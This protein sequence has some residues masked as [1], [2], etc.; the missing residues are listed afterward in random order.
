MDQVGGIAGTVTETLLLELLD[1]DGSSCG[2]LTD[3]CYD[4]ADPYAVTATFHNGPQPVRWTFARSLLLEGMYA[5]VGEGDVHVWPCLDADGA[6]VVMLE[7][8]SPD[9]QVLVLANMRGL[10]RFAARTVVAVPPGTESSHL[11]VDQALRHLLA[12]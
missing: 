5:P 9:G 11:D 8:C 6:T 4:A 3:F 7:L 1:D 2:L 12:R 10:S